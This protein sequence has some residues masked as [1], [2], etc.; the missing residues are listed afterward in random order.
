[1]INPHQLDVFKSHVMKH[2]RHISVA[3]FSLVEVTLAVAIA[4]L[5][6]ITFLGLLPQGL[7]IS[8]KTSLMTLHS[9]VL[10]QIIRDLENAAWD[11]MPAGADVR[12]YFDDQGVEVDASSERLTLVAQMDFSKQA[13]LPVNDDP[14]RFLR[15]VIVRIATTASPTFQFGEDNK[16]AY[17]SYHHLV[18]KSRNAIAP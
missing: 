10:E 13:T 17:S 8:R 7:E 3:A 15:R 5:A 2:R 14:Q 9:N 1:M 6:L 4:S 12:R 18:S 11:T 16:F